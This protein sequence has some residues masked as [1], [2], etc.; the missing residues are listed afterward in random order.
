MIVDNMPEGMTFD[1]N[2]PENQDWVMYDN[3]LYYN[4]LSGKLILP[5]E[6]QYFTLVL[7]LELK[8]AGTYR[9]IVS[10]RDI[11]LMGDELPVYDFSSLNNTEGGE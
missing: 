1:P 7:D 3:L 2:L 4:G 8:Q 5:N 10:A 9:N 11:T 6:K